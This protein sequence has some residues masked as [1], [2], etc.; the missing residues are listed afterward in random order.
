MDIEN[1]TM[2]VTTTGRCSKVLLL[3]TGKRID[4]M[5]FTFAK[6]TTKVVDLSD[7]VVTVSRLASVNDVKI[8]LE[9]VLAKENEWK[10]YGV[11]PSTATS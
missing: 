1:P 5:D 3:H 9:R 7:M 2:S 11:S 10:I 8:E 4:N 6:R